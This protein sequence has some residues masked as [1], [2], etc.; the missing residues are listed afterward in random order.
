MAVTSSPGAF[1]RA[2]LFAVATLVLGAIAIALFARVTDVG[3]TRLHYAA[4]VESRDLRFEDRSDG[5]VAVYDAKDGTLVDLVTPGT[6]GFIRTVMRGLAHSRAEQGFGPEGSFK[7]T[8][9]DDGR[10]SI[11][12]PMTGRQIELVGFGAPNVAVF[13]NLLESGRSSP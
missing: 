10:L 2:P 9:W 8:R 11:S 6:K 4:P 1:P 13:A 12:D 3:T 7:L 5:N